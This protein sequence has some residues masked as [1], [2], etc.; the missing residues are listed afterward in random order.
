MPSAVRAYG[1]A[2]SG[3]LA[4][5][6]GIGFRAFDPARARIHLTGAV[7]GSGAWLVVGLSESNWGGA[8]LPFDLAALG[9]PGCWL[10]ASAEVLV[11]VRAGTTGNDRGCAYVD[12]PRLGVTL[13]GQWVVPDGQ[14]GFALSKGLRW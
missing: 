4:A 2:C 8:S 5:A 3:A 14:G 7:P 1:N 9:L 12:V 10:N 6:P 11:P 13:R